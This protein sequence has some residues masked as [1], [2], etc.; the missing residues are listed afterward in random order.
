MNPLYSFYDNSAD[1]EL[2]FIMAN[3]DVTADKGRLLQQGCWSRGQLKR[4]AGLF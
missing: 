1:W 3:H 4:M 2:S